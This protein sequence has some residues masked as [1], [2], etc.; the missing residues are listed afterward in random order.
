[1]TSPAYYRPAAW[2]G[3]AVAAGAC[4]LLGVVLWRFSAH[5]TETRI[6]HDAGVQ[7]QVAQ[8]STA[9]LNRI[10]NAARERADSLGAVASTARARFVRDSTV[11]M[12]RIRALLAQLRDTTGPAVLY[13]PP[14]VTEGLQ[15]CVGLVSSCALAQAADSAH[16]AALQGQLVHAQQQVEQANRAL[17]QCARAR[18]VEQV[19]RVSARTW[20]D[21][22]VGTL[23]AMG[24]ALVMGVRC[25]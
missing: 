22:K 12:V 19:Q 21:V 5:V 11:S 1:M 6:A 23:S 4:V 8:D 15:S 25:R 2:R 16:I 10:A 14:A 13:A 3:W 7:L 9:V 24:G 18:S 20:R 17:E